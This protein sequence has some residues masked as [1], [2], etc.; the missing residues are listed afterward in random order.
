M[1]RV[2]A[3]VGVLGATFALW[4]TAGVAPAVANTGT[5]TFTTSPPNAIVGGPTYAPQASD[6]STQATISIDTGSTTNAACSLSAAGVVSFDH[7]G[8]CVI[9]ANV[10]GDPQAQQTVAVA[11]AA[12][13]TSLAVGSASLTATVAANA[14]GGGTPAG[15]VMFTVGGR[16]LGSSGLTNGV[17]TLS[18]SVPANVTEQILATYQGDGDYQSSSGSQVVSGPDIQRSFVTR[19]VITA[20]LTSRQPR[21]RAGWWHTSVRVRF[22]CSAAGSSIIGGCPRPVLLAR[23][24]RDLTITRTIRTAAGGRA[25]VTLRGIKIDLTRPRV[26]IAGIRSHALYGTRMP[27]GSCTASDRFSGI[28][29]CRIATHVVHRGSL[30]TI[31]FTATAISRAG[32][33][34]S[35]SE[36]VYSKP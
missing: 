34:G 30:E 8:S 19:P 23:S 22:S 18:Y 5:V 16:L 36:T 4:L 7:A 2:R 21:N 14:P 9:D 20:R 31:T 26:E 29:S 11:A 28:A 35:V 3:V 10:S 6:G 13:A 25:T 15:T 32:T 33:R 1:Q 24:G 27:R 12:T 17:A